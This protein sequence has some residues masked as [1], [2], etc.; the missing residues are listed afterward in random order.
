MP[1]LNYS[2]MAANNGGTG[3]GMVEIRVIEIGYFGVGC[4]F[5]KPGVKSEQLGN[6][7]LKFRNVVIC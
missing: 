6:S 3:V 1:D 4:S 7:F 5:L 2:P